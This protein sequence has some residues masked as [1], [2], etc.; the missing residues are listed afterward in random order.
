MK[1]KIV[2]QFIIFV[3]SSIYPAFADTYTW[4]ETND[5]NWA[6]TSNWSPAGAPG[7]G[8]SVT[9]NSAS[10][11]A[12][13]D[14][15]SGLTI[16]DIQFD[17]A[18]AAAYTIGSGGAKSQ[19]LTLDDGGSITMSSA[20]ANN[21]TINSNITLGNG[22]ATASFS[23]TNDTAGNALTIAGAI[24][25]S[26]GAYTRTLTVTGDGTITLSGAITDGGGTVGLTKSGSGTLNT[27]G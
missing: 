24:T 14:V 23:L 26:T 5:G 1:R 2:F 27:S 11:N 4:Q 19:T 8:D 10:D 25:G 13:I 20:V 18:S 21:E 7:T 6:T 17:T 22:T 15:G 9:F 12:I 16:K 3:F